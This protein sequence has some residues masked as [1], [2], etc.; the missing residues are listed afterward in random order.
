[1][2]QIV[3]KSIIISKHLKKTKPKVWPLK[4]QQNPK[5]LKFQNTWPTKDGIDIRLLRP[6]D[7]PVVQLPGEPDPAEDGPGLTQY[8]MRVSA[9]GPDKARHMAVAKKINGCV[10]KLSQ[11][12]PKKTLRGSPIDRRPSTSEAP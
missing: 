5:N 11:P 2:T 4:F 12:Q 7:S 3:L 8:Q 9:G 10:I 1:M 6:D